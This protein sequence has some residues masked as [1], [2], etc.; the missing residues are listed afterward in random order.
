MTKEKTGRIIHVERH[1][2]PSQIFTWRP[3]WIWLV[4]FCQC[5]IQLQSCNDS[6]FLAPFCAV[7]MAQASAS[8]C[9]D[10]PCG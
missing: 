8:P 4:F 5:L 3:P 10:T 6:H 9:S 1:K 2:K 7:I